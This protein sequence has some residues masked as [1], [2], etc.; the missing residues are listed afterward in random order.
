MEEERSIVR[1]LTP[2]KQRN[3]LSQQQI[4]DVRS[5]ERVRSVRKQSPI[6]YIQ[7]EYGESRRIQLQMANTVLNKSLEDVREEMRQMREVNRQLRNQVDGL[8]Q[9]VERREV[10]LDEVGEQ[11]EKLREEKDEYGEKM[12]IKERQLFV[13][14][15]DLQD[16]NQRYNLC[17]EELL[18][19]KELIANFQSRQLSERQAMEKRMRE[20]VSEKEV[21]VMEASQVYQLRIVELQTRLNCEKSALSE[22][23]LKKQQNEIKINSLSRQ[24]QILR[25]QLNVKEVQMVNIS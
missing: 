8:R 16:L 12:R 11:M 19:H 13:L 4:V 5:R 1:Y 25:E 17:W 23:L 20:Q 2:T 15:Q 24:L 21:K 18:A 22:C 9:L 7:S 14:A 3:F 10:E 6:S